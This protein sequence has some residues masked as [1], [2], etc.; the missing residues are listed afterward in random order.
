LLYGLLFPCKG[1]GQIKLVR[2]LFVINAQM[3]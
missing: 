3:L 2:Q 1:N